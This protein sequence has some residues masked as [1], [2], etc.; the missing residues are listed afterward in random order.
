MKTKQLNLY[1][2]VDSIVENLANIYKECRDAY[3]GD[4]CYTM[5]MSEYDDETIEEL[6]YETTMQIN[7]DMKTYLNS[8]DRHI[9]GNFNNISSDYPKDFKDM[10]NRLN[11]GDNSKE[12]DEDREFLT[13]WFWDTFGTYGLKYNF[14]SDLAEKVYCY[15][16]EYFA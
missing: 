16:N 12:S 15:A 3:I 11:N 10:V 4:S 6:A 13:D 8:K 7:A 9:V 14:A 1:V 2:N 5:L